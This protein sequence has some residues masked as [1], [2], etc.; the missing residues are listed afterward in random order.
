MIHHIRI[1]RR[2]RNAEQMQWRGAR[3]GAINQAQG[4]L[5]RDPRATE[6]IVMNEEGFPVWREK[7]AV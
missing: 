4:M 1:E 2:G 5:A 7:R 6:A 3:E